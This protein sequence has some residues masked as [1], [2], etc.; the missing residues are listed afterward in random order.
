MALVVLDASV[1]IAFLDPDDVL[2]DAAVAAL[3]EHQHNELLIPLSVYAEVLVAPYRRG[4]DAVAEVE[5]F[6][7]DFSVRVETI[8]LGTARAAAKLRSRVRSLRLP[9]A[10]VL[11]TADDLGAHAVLTGDES[12]AR[13]SGRVTVIR[14]G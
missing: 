9:D 4:A 10:L 8:N 5:A 7:G 2:H 3:T 6:L 1:V 12:W 14:R 11:A 13:L